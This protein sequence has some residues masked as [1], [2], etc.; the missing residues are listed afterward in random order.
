MVTAFA[1]AANDAIERWRDARRTV[2]RRR[3]SASSI[4][5]WRISTRRLFALEQLLAPAARRH[6]LLGALHSV[7]RSAGKLRD[8][9]VAIRLLAAET[10][11]FASAGT[12]LSHLRRDLPRLRRRTMRRLRAVRTRHLRKIIDGW[13]QPHPG[14]FEAL[15]R[16]RAAARLAAHRSHPPGSPSHTTAA[17]HRQRLHL[18]SLR[19]MIELC[20]TANCPLPY[21][22][23][24]P[25]RLAQL[26]SVLGD[27]TD[28]QV[29]LRMID[30]RGRRHPRWQAKAAELR[31]DL[32]RRRERLLDQLP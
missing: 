5:G 8:A 9:Q 2:L 26:Q 22:K 19:Y 7:F 17:L 15:A 3:A 31:R 1:V 27:I 11:H 20:R 6:Q 4:H 24:A 29:L 28:L 21:K 12:L 30:H 14:T 13:R 10:Q 32:L 23:W 25:R 16:N 18:K